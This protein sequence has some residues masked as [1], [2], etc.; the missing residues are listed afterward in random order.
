M[1]GPSLCSGEL[2]G[3]TWPTAQR[4]VSIAVPLACFV[5]C[6]VLTIGWL[7]NPKR[8]QG[9]PVFT[10]VGGRAPRRSKEAEGPPGITLGKS[11]FQLGVQPSEVE[12][13]DS[14]RASERKSHAAKTPQPTESPRI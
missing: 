13:D 6:C 11:S 10:S 4:S 2:A 1:V 7:R 8:M 3:L 5:C 9:E 14:A 12:A